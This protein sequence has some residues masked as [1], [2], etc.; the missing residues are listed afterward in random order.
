MFLLMPRPCPLRRLR[1]AEIRDKYMHPVLCRTPTLQH[2]RDPRVLPEVDNSKALVS[3]GCLKIIIRTA[4]FRDRE[5]RAIASTM[6]DEFL[7]E[8]R[9][10]HMVAEWISTSKF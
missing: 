4:L 9:A 3:K 6:D 10:A 2:F 8:N 5:A 7:D 1:L